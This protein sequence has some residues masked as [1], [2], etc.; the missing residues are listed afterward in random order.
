MDFGPRK[1]TSG[2]EAAR[3]F[4]D[5]QLIMP[6]FPM[7]LMFGDLDIF[8]SQSASLKNRCNA[9]S[10]RRT[11]HRKNETRC[12]RTYIFTMKFQS[13]R[14]SAFYTSIVL[15]HK[16]SGEHHWRAHRQFASGNRS[17]PDP[18]APCL[19]FRTGA[20]PTRS[21]AHESFCGSRAQT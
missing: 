3:L 2:I 6:D 19:G 9:L 12:Y 20:T 7:D 11:T 13:F 10:G 16:A 8:A 18:S 1:S 4:F 21:M 14:P 15:T 5:V 17:R